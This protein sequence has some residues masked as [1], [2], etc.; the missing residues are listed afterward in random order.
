VLDYP[1]LLT[2]GVYRCP[3]LSPRGN[4]VF[5]AVDHNSCWIAETL[6]GVREVLPGDDVT[7]INDQLWDLLNRLDPVSAVA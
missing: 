3:C 6:G 1:R 2:R 5:Y 4:P 7:Q